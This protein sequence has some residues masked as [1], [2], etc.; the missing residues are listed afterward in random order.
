MSLSVVVTL[1]FLGGKPK[2]FSIIADAGAD[3]M[4]RVTLFRNVSR[5]RR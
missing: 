1:L 4:S 3:V 5:R 2:N